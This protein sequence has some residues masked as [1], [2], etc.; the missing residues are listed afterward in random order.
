M[1]EDEFN[2]NKNFIIKIMKSLNG[3]SFKVTESYM[4]STRILKF[5][6]VLFKWL[7]L[8]QFAAVQFSGLPRKVFDFNE[9]Q[10]GTAFEALEKEPHMKDL[11]NTHRALKFVL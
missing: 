9:Y 2:E 1:T 7:C 6:A 10:A 4:I 11:T 8:F 5:S 3:T